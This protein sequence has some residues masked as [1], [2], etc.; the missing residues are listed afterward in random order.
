M[1][2]GGSTLLWS[3]GKDKKVGCKALCALQNKQLVLHGLQK[4]RPLQNEAKS[5]SF[6]LEDDEL[7]RPRATP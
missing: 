3:S 2:R 5:D 4:A 6:E 1:G 7:M